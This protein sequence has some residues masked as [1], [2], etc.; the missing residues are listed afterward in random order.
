M[1]QV[2]RPQDCYMLYTDQAAFTDSVHMHAQCTHTCI[3]Q[4][5]VFCSQ[6]VAKH[7]QKVEDSHHKPIHV[8]VHVLPNF[9]IVK[10]V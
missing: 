5:N 1:R 10:A 2:L 7:T 3:I 4:L 8:H 9:F 6:E